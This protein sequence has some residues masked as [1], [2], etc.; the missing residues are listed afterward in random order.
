M[1]KKRIMV[2][3]RNVFWILAA[4]L[5]MSPLR[6]LADSELGPITLTNPLGDITITQF[7]DEILSIVVMLGTPV[8]VFFIIYSG[9]LFV[10]A[11][12][13]PEKLTKARTTLLWVVI[14]TTILLGASVLST[15]IQGTIESISP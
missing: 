15:A 4:Y 12:G 10:V 14:G 2:T 8:A 7:I 6:L 3:L 5:Y 11:Q 1:R 9:F 13:N